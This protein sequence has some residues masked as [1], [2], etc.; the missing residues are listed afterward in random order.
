MIYSGCENRNRYP[1]RKEIIMDFSSA[2]VKKFL[3]SF[4][5][6]INRFAYWGYSF[7]LIIVIFVLA[8]VA[9]TGEVDW[10]VVPMLLVSLYTSIPV[11]VKRLHDTNRSGWC[12]LLFFI[13]VFGVLYILVV[14][15]LAMGDPE[16]NKYGNPPN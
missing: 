9:D 7:A 2:I 5:G 8:L 4:E 14:C 3:F 13:P 1:R 16:A 10:L 6:R 15:G 12:F 11:H